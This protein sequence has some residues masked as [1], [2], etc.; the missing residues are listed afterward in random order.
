MSTGLL[1][2]VRKGGITIFHG[3]VRS[4]REPKKRHI[5]TFSGFSMLPIGVLFALYFFFQNTPNLLSHQN[6]D[7]FGDDSALQQAVAGNIGQEDFLRAYDMLE[8]DDETD[9]ESLQ[10][11]AR[12]FYF[13]NRLR[14]MVSGYPI[15]GMVPSIVR[16]E[17]TVAA[18]L[19]GIAKKE[20]DW[21]RHAP[22]RGGV[23]C[24]NYW[25]YKGVASA[26]SSM[27]YACF[28][29]PE[30][31]VSVV[32]KRIHNL[33]IVSGRNTSA[34]MIVWKCGSSCDGHS[35]DSVSGWIRDVDRY[36][37]RVLAMNRD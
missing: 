17:R 30:E 18:L 29:S 3:I 7:V 16:Q 34:K 15:E 4:L 33:S 10:E 35:P 24:F 37:T 14:Q 11:S 27:G 31:A 13:E 9:V 22:S 19:I 26:G 5:R 12:L 6:R 1:G 36:F 21:G 20:S 32:G 28:S 8:S 23:D 25:G 2:Y